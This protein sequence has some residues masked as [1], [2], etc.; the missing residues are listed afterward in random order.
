MTPVPGLKPACTAS[1]QSTSSVTMRSRAFVRA[2]R[3]CSQSYA[4][5]YATWRSARCAVCWASRQCSYH[6]GARA[7]AGAARSASAV[8]QESARGMRPAVPRAAARTAASGTAARASARN[9]SSWTTYI[10]GR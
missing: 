5:R 7:A 4:S 3:A 6:W 2:G 9:G 8:R 1:S 10:S